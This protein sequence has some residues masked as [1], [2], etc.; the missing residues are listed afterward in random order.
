M[1]QYGF[2]A[3][4]YLSSPALRQGPLKPCLLGFFRQLW[5]DILHSQQEHWN[6]RRLGDFSA[7]LEPIH[8]GHGEINDYYIRRK[9]LGS[10]NRI[11]PVVSFA[12]DLPVGMLLDQPAQQTADG[13]VVVSNKNTNRHT[14]PIEISF[15]RAEPLSNTGNT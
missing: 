2:D 14:A 15:E 4:D 8:L 12:T 13:R 6:A 7:C 11:A 3:G 10:L 9:L 1:L 5:G